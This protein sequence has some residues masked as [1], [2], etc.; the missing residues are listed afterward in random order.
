MDRSLLKE[1]I[2]RSSAFG[3]T[4]LQ[5][6]ELRN[7]FPSGLPTLHETQ[8]AG[9]ARRKLATIEHPQESYLRVT[10]C[11]ELMHSW[12]PSH[13][14]FQVCMLGGD[15]NVF[16]I[17]QFDVECGHS[18][19]HPGNGKGETFMEIDHRPPRELCTSLV[20]VVLQ[21][22]QKHGLLLQAS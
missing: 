3:L 9:S 8:A 18:H 2:L 1:W 15:A 14:D 12:L 21:H 5:R 19:M 10:D 6:A 11:L 7:D 22:L 16:E 13:T 17:A 4:S 20:Q